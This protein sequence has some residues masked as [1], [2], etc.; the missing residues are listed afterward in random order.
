MQIKTQQANSGK[1][2]F[3]PTF[4]CTKHLQETKCQLK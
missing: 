4:P 3:Y 2:I 1:S